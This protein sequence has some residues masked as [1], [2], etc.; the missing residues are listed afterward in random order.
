MG[1][2]L[3]ILGSLGLFLFGMKLMS[4]GLQKLSGEKLRSVM[5]SMT[6]NRFKGVF[7]GFVVTGAIQSSS[8]T[9]VMVV[10]FVNAG[11]LTL[12]EAIGVIMGANL[13]T[14]ATAWIIAILGF[15]FSL[16]D[17]AL[18][19]VGFGMIATFFKKTA[20]KNTGEFLVGF[21]LLFLGLDFLK[22][23]VPGMSADSPFIQ[24]IAHYSNM[25]FLS[26][27]LFLF[28]GVL[29]TLI[30]QSSSVAMA[31]TITMAAKGWIGLDLAAAIVLGENIGTTV[32][33]NIAA[34]TA[35][36]AAKRAA[37]AHFVF[38]VLGV[39]WMLFVFY[40]FMDFIK[41]M[42]P[43]DTAPSLETLKAMGI[44]NFD[45]L[46]GAARTEALERIAIPTRLAL[47]HTMFN[48]TN[49]VLLIGFVPQIE[50]IS[51][52]LIKPR[53][54]GKRRSSLQRIEYLSNNLA[55]MGELA[56]YEGQ[57]E[58]V[59]LAN[60]SGEMFHG[61][62]HI[63]Q[64]PD[65]DLSAE[66]TRLRDL[67]QESDKLSLALTNFFVQC[68]SHELSQNSI[69]LVTRNMLIV[70]ELEELCDSCYRLITMA[71]KNYRKQYLEKM[72]HSPA[73]A[74]FSAEMT[75]FVDFADESLLHQSISKDDLE[76]SMKMRSKLEAVRKALR[77]EAIAQMEAGGVTRGGI[78]FIEVLSA[79]E[80]VNAHAMNILEAMNLK[81]DYNA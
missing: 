8:A 34:L 52:W 57:K 19:I 9:T 66:V 33:A 16:S 62:V 49:I 15:K 20:W 50:K 4:E 14:T 13:G 27:L 35:S 32:T 80:R 75:R 55:E 71:R 29:L 28:F 67:E 54:D 41:W 51:S 30:V 81:M 7:S 42:T 77:R 17:I 2:A 25:G 44:T 22:G 73:F 31:I 60:M 48:L 72:L 68:S 53:P 70:P 26:V 12:R 18:P 3:E 40:W 45:S 65:K 78:L 56:L 38:N 79:C 39:I 69:K 63:V 37:I 59:N 1:T 58:M 43:L 10:S 74:E 21:G 24:W 6:G 61:F 76:K 5:R 23:A 46:Q 47:F 64:N 36:V 11:L